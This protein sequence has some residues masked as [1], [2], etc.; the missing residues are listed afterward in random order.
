MVPISLRMKTIADMVPEGLS[1]ADIGCDHGFVSIYL[2][3]K[4]K[5]PYALAMDVNE[6]PLVRAKE[7]IEQYGLEKVIKT[8]LSDGAKELK[9]YET[10]AAVIAGMG[11]RLITRILED[12][13]DKFKAMKSFVL[14]PH[15]DIPYVREYL[16]EQGFV[17]D[18]EDMVFDEGKYY[19]IMRC[20]YLG[21]SGILSNIEKEY[22]PVLLAK[23]HNVLREYL[24]KEQ[25]KMTEIEERLSAKM[26]E[27]AKTRTEDIVNR[28]KQIREVI[29]E[30][31][32]VLKGM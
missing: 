10:E 14:S 7:H 18:D 26:N 28:A 27:S 23:K 25:Q 9:A 5:A 21:E 1:V 13:I 17:I 24:V 31:E 15:S 3:T 4:L 22:G 8:R 32:I 29:D 20:H 11:G 30:I 12:S 19:V 2:V 6:G 16:Y